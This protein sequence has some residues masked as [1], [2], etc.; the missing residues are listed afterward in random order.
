MLRK[1]WY[2]NFIIGLLSLLFFVL[3]TNNSSAQ[4][5]LNGRIFEYNSH[6]PVAG[7]KIE[8]LKSH[9][10]GASTADGKFSIKAIIGD[11]ICYSRS[12]YKPDTVLVTNL[13][14]KEIFLEF[15]QTLLK[16]VKIINKET[17]LGTL[18]TPVATPFGGNTVRYQT[19]ANGNNKGGLKIMIPGSDKEQQ[20]KIKE[21]KREADDETASQIAKIFSPQ[22][23]QNYVPIKDQEL[24]NFSLLY[25]PPLKTYHAKF[26]I[27]LYVDSCYK[28]FVKIPVE[29]RR[30]KAFLDLNYKP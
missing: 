2:K 4:N 28:E 30:S 25:T 15:N 16:E 12:S 8:N 7:V 29:K 27:A 3:F 20:K 18:A 23:L 21:A 19:D 6:T 9:L 22:N 11:L 5:I 26:N 24:E 17:N 14:Y 1:H 13:K 10:T